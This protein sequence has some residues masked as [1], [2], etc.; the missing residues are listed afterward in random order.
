MR[1]DGSEIA[2]VSEQGSN[3]ELWIVGS[4]GAPSERVCEDCGLPTDWR[5]DGSGIL[6][7][8]WHRQRPFAVSFLDRRTGQQIEL[9]RHPT[10]DL[11]GARFSPDMRW[12][13]FQAAPGSSRRVIYVAPFAGDRKIERT[14]WIQITEEQTKNA[15]ACWGAAD[16]LYFRSNRC[17]ESGCIWGQR[18]DLANRRV[19]GN[20]FEVYHNPQLTSS[21]R[22]V[23][24]VDRL[25]LSLGGGRF[26]YSVTLSATQL[27]VSEPKPGH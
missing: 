18:L 26:F 12:L 9:L 24:V 21:D 17:H 3:K 6:F 15:S 8:P 25:G 1:P 27:W 23:L 14:E 13:S 22:D 10:Y 20:P 5:A 11:Q 2:Y 7:T 19:L 4:Q 16:L